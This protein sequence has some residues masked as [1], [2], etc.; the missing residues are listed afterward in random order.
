MGVR[1]AGIGFLRRWALVCS[2]AVAA[3]QPGGAS[4]QA[5]DAPPPPV[6][7]QQRFQLPGTTRDVVTPPTP[8]GPAPS[9]AE[10]D[11]RAALAQAPCPFT[12]PALRVQ[13]A[14]VSFTRPDGTSPL[15]PEIAQSLARLTLPTGDQ[16]L[17][18]VC[19]LRDQANAALRRDGWVASVQIPAQEIAG[20]ELRL[21]IV[22]ARIVDVRVRGDAGPY[23][24]TLRRRIEQL[25]AI[26]P[27]NERE[28]ER[29]LLLAGDVPGLDV[30]LALRPA[31]QG[32][33]GEVVGDLTIV[34]QRGAFLA[35]AQNYNAR[36]L[37][38][39][40]GYA[41][42]EFYGLTG[43]GDITYVGASTTFDY[44]EQA[45]AQIGHIATL[46]TAGTTLGGRFS[47]AWSRPDLGAL[48]YRT[49]T[50]IAGFDVARPLFRSVTSN[51]GVAFGFDYVNQVTNIFNNDLKIPLTRDRLRVLYGAL[52]GDHRELN[53]DGSTRLLAR[54]RLEVRQ[55]ID[56]F[57]ASNPG[58]GTTGV[59]QS[60]IDGDSTATIIR[61]D[62]ELYSQITHWLAYS[63]RLLGQYTNA[64]VLNYEEFSLGNLTVGRGY[65]PG[66]NSGDKAVGT[67]TE[68][69]AKLP[70]HDR[71]GTQVFGFYDAVLLD[72]NDPSAIEVNRTLRSWGGGVRFTLEGLALLEVTYAHPEDRALTLDE[73]PPP[74]RVLVSLTFQLR[75][76]F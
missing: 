2:A 64:P 51:G 61:A 18:V 65:D 6:N 44:E 13:I 1:V 25:Q 4:A 47:Y 43:L 30:Q 31:D 48:D 55:G 37:G 46:D 9:R 76:L 66:S 36:L 49:D 23:E 53:F 26:D 63:F 3:M 12:D 68:L 14:R 28:A 67:R 39:E 69:I 22:T 45:I 35:N 40:T 27:L 16:P 74:D 38:R 56:I 59:S 8:S 52:S 34:F 15:Q 32:A 11:A 50:L 57:D 62:V 75:D 54:A 19:D 7:E 41:R 33:Q 73:A 71:V 5:P 42:A 58:V 24:A 20:G 60:R 17:S 21:H 10:V 29:I 70:L 72:N